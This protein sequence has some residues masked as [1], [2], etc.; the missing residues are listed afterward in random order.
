MR[1]SLLLLVL[2]LPLS[3]QEYSERKLIVAGGGK[4]PAS[5]WEAFIKLTGGPD[6]RFLAVPQA[7]ASETAGPRIVA[8]LKEYGAR[9]SSILKLDDPD[10]ARRQIGQADGIWFGGGQQNRLM[11]Q[12]EAAGVASTFRS[13]LQNGV[14]FG[15]SSAGAAV[16]SDLMIAGDALP[17]DRGLAL[18]PEVI[19]DQHFVARRRF[20]RS[21]RTVMEHPEKFGVG[22]GE[23]T[24]VLVTEN[25]FKVLGKG[26]VTVI[27]ARHANV[28][29]SA[30]GN[31][32]SWQNIRTHWLH[33]GDSFRFATAPPTMGR[34]ALVIH[35]GA[36]RISPESLEKFGE[37]N[38][39]KTLRRALEAGHAILNKGGASLDAIEAAI[40]ILED[41]PL[42]NAGKGA[43]FTS[44]GENE[45]DASIMDGS[46][47]KAGAV[48]GVTI[49]KN[50]IRAARAVME[51]TPH[52]LLAGDGADEF[53]KSANLE[54]VDRKYFHTE[55]RWESWQKRRTEKP[56]LKPD[57]KKRSSLSADHKYG[58]VGAVALD[59]RGNLAAGTSTGGMTNKRF[60]RVGDSPIIAAG[61]YADNRF[62]GISCTG[63]GEFFIRHAV[64]YDII[65]RTRYL[66]TD[67]QDSA[68]KVVKEKLAKIGAGGGIIGLDPSGNVV[69]SF[70]TP[71][72]F[73]G[74]VDSKGNITVKIYQ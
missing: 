21:L 19:V 63:H 24:A 46:T 29:G 71:S 49:V 9:K 72:M 52:V 65:A 13:R 62:G 33:A 45:M 4:L 6:K 16:Q 51:Q 18:W 12:L 36:G 59:H 17:I 50:P 55:H 28:S 41:S 30:T 3:A 44:A 60:G 73:R 34:S 68:D 53:A 5:I 43:V 27:D 37:A 38:Y 11:D 14:T 25:S 22:I 67:L 20:N 56:V 2:T 1:T 35:G 69:A 31:T 70:N 10:Q 7:S 74:W 40:T 57:A 39:R 23:S 48:G 32:N 42:F 15:G 26:S 54:I 8:T 66:Q 58:T 64:A 61:T 47:M